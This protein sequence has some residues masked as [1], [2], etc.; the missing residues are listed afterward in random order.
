MQAYVYGALA[1]LGA[2]AT[3][4]QAATG[5]LLLAIATGAVA[6]YLAAS[7]M[8]ARAPARPA[9]SNQGAIRAV[10]DSVF[11]LRGDP[12]HSFPRDRAPDLARPLIAISFLAFAL[13]VWMLRG[14]PSRTV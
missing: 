6:L 11:L 14:Q 8:A 13:R 1:V 9:T 4:V 10:L 12:R 2:A 5:H 7:A 3:T